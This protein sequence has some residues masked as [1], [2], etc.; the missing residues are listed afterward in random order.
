MKRSLS[1]VVSTDFIDD[2]YAAARAAGAWGG[3]LLG[4]GGGGFL[5]VFAPPERHPQIMRALDNLLYVPVEFETQGS[6]IIFY[7]PDSYSRISSRPRV[8]GR[9]KPE[10][11][12]ES[13]T[14]LQA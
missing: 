2:A 7:D 3:K 9:G 12:P 1:S 8:N 10:L 5:L 6:Q 4:A 11:R 13:A 14:L